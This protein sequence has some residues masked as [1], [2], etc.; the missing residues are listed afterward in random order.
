MGYRVLAHNYRSSRMMAQVKRAAWVLHL[1]LSQ[2][3]LCSADVGKEL[4][5]D[6]S[7]DLGHDYFRWGELCR[8]CGCGCCWS[9]ADVQ[10]VLGVGVGMLEFRGLK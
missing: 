1:R 8:R 5:D 6:A 9:C 7:D 4:Q 3:V 10:L 2:G